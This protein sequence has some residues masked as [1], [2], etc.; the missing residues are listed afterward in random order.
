MVKLQVDLYQTFPWVT[1]FLPDCHGLAA[2]VEAGLAANIKMDS[3]VIRAGRID[4]FAQRRQEAGDIRG[5]T[6][7]AKPGLAMVITQAGERVD[8]EKGF[9]IEGNAANH[10]II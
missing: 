4:V 5:A 10:P 6:G 3:Q 2:P 8:V 7:T 1:G 9:S